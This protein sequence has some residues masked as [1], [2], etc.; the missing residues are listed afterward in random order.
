MRVRKGAASV[1]ALTIV[2]LVASFG[3][4]G[5]GAQEKRTSDSS[6]VTIQVGNG[7]VDAAPSKSTATGEPTTLTAN[8]RFSEANLHKVDEFV[9]QQMDQQDLPS[10]VVAVWTPGEGEYLTAQGKANLETGEQRGLGQPFRIASITKTFTATA[11][12][13]LVDKGKLETS[14]KLSRWYPDFPNAEKIT[15]DDLLRMRSGIPDFTDEEFMKN[16]YAHPAADITAQDTI[17]RSAKKVNQFKE[18]GQETVYTNTNYVLLQEIVGKVSGEPLGDRIEEGILRPLGMNDSFY[19][20]EDGLPGTLHGYSWDPQTKEFQDNTVL[21]PAVPG[22]AGAMVSTLSDLRPYAKALCE[23]DL[24]EPQT[25]EQ[26]FKS[27]A[28][29]GDPPFVR[30]GQGLVFLGDWCGHNGTIFGFSSEMF[31]LPEKQAVILVDVNRLDLDDQ[32]KSTEIFLGVSKILF[33]EY[34]DW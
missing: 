28:I 20:T 21:N 27:D 32:S 10:V 6:E 24:L 5:E 19:A 1:A 26:R 14:D 8:E 13:Q 29:K 25:Q 17:E 16:W 2:G 9:A 18:P 3:C 30:Y 4:Q 11:I 12:L 22:G 15:V 34:V 33:P 23:G 7:V 31:Y